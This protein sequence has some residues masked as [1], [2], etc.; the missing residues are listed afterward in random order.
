M[1]AEVELPAGSVQTLQDANLWPDGGHR[2][3]LFL[4][5]A[6]DDAERRLLEER[7][8]ARSL[9]AGARVES[10]VLGD[11][12]A[13]L[14]RLLAELPGDAWLQPLRLIWLP[15]PRPGAS[16]LVQDLIALGI[17]NP[18][19]RRRR[20]ILAD[21]PERVRVLRG[22][23]ARIDTVRADALRSWGA[24]AEDEVLASFVRRQAL[25]VLDR[26]ERNARGARYKVPRLLPQDV[27]ANREFRTRLWQ[28]A[29]EADR[30]PGE[31]E[32]EAAAYLEEMAATQT[33]LTLDA[34][35][36]IMRAMYTASHDREIDV[37]EAQLA[38]V[39]GLI[40]TRPVA[41]VMS[42]KSMLDS[43][44]L[45]CVLF[46]RNQPMPLTFGGINLNTPG[47]GALA[48]RAGVIFLRRSFQDNE[49][50]KSVFRRYIDYLIE[51]RFSLL[52]A[53]EGTR[54]RT[55][56]LL[57]PRYGL[58][59]Y[60]VEAILRTGISNVTFVP[61][62][63]TYDQVPEVGD[64]VVEQQGRDKKAEGAGWFLRFIR[65]R[66]PHGRIFLRFGAPLVLGDVLA[67]G[68][69]DAGLE[70]GERQQAVQK[71]AFE[72]A[73]RMNDATPI[74]PVAVVTMILL[75]AGNRAQTLGTIQY[76]ARPGMALVRKRRIEVVGRADFKDPEAVRETLAQL[77]AT[78]VVSYHDEGEERLFGIAD[79]AH[80][81]A[82]YYRNTIIHYFVSDAFCEVALLRA[83]GRDEAAFWSEMEALRDLF[84]HEFYFRL[85]DAWMDRAESRVAL[86]FRR[87]R[88]V[89]PQG[90]QA[91]LAMLGRV[92]P[93]FA[94]ALLRA[95]VDA[96]SVVARRLARQGTAAVEDKRA[97]VTGCLATGRQLRL[98]GRIFSEE[99]VSRS[100]FE[101]ALKLAEQRGLT[102][103]AAGVDA[104][105]VAFFEELADL[106]AR[107]DVILDLTTR[108][109]L[110]QEL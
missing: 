47:I 32:T 95:F 59:N 12:D 96:Y 87:W 26:V 4:L 79:D 107:L 19:P 2:T 67:E 53:L 94:H 5:D 56:K 58:F 48:K 30:E 17:E 34:L 83:A 23:G 24:E 110:A 15:K 10:A 80:L 11:D 82:A 42:H 81:K 6:E 74:T 13:E 54:S 61:V 1:D 105:R 101:T 39:E 16:N 69:L 31:V 41:F 8:R 68:A 18:G 29:Q 108:R 20:R 60:V 50:Y 64:Y 78:G 92:R 102:G 72:T 65:E 7:I 97:F 98:E 27:F 85:R 46:D 43:I 66:R 73:V 36:A 88:E 86:R 99:S 22:D 37:V 93:L 52:W 76:L 109:T 103:G 91:V 14:R 35:V 106:G 104:A 40:R 51:K 70:A 57:P 33:P 63:I 100:L 75:A 28:V 84:K 25:V 77:H 38:E 45:Q 49:I 44:A 62:N 21:E 71:L 55:G 90:E 3:V 89:L 9:D